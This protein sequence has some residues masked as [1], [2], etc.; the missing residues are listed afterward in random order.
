MGAASVSCSAKGYQS[1]LRAW[2]LPRLFFGGKQDENT[3]NN[4]KQVHGFP[5]EI[6]HANAFRND[7]SGNGD[8]FP[9]ECTRRPD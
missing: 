1:L 7:N 5:S 4:E 2:Q 3:F 6:I 9:G 8:Q